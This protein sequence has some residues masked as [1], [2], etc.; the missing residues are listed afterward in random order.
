MT[1]QQTPGVPA[2]SNKDIASNLYHRQHVFSKNSFD[3]HFPCVTFTHTSTPHSCAVNNVISEQ[4][5][6][7]LAS[8][9][10]FPSFP[11]P[12]SRPTHC[13]TAASSS[14]GFHGHPN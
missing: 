7:P 12:A 8:F 5:T 3:N 9:A 11:S 10:Q 2:R 4:L 13:E 1:H 6:N 14:A